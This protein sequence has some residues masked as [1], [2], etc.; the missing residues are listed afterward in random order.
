MACNSVIKMH[1]LLLVLKN[2]Y[3]QDNGILLFKIKCIYFYL[4]VK[5]REIHSKIKRTQ[6]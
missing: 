3:T 2:I 4:I 1:H 5:K 6:M